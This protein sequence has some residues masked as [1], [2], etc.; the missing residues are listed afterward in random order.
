MP[1]KVDHEQ[2][3]SHIVEALLRIAGERGL[4]AVSL[5]E[6]AAEAGV[7]MGAVQHYF[8]SKDEML[9]YAMQ[10]WLSFT[11]HQRFTRAVQA[12]LAG[13]DVSDPAVVLHAVAAAYLPHDE[14][15]RAN[16][17]V[18]LAFIGRAADEPAIAEALRPAHAGLLDVVGRILSGGAPGVGE[19]L[20]GRPAPDGVRRFIALLDGLRLHVL[21]GAVA[22]EDALGLLDRYL[23]EALVDTPGPPAVRRAP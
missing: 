6:V 9:R 5:R 21:A 23:S 19:P 3:R 13:A 7:S 4:E 8:A 1:K 16:A 22:Y 2:R 15:S 11:V 10:H 17:K 12:R 20:T 18:A 14:E